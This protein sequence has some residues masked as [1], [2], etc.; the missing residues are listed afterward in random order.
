MSIMDACILNNCIRHGS[1]QQSSALST[2]LLVAMVTDAV[3]TNVS[4]HIQS[5]QLN[6]LRLF[7]TFKAFQ[8]RRKSSRT[9]I[10]IHSSSEILND[11]WQL[12][13]GMS[14]RYISGTAEFNVYVF[15][16]I[17]I[18]EPSR[19]ELSAA[20]QAYSP[21]DKGN[22]FL[23]NVTFHILHNHCRESRIF[24]MGIF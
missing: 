22:R 14:D 6:C 12:Y 7:Q 18:T 2:I 9:G 4:D 13:I 20:P 1:H 19:Y 10:Q 24:R 8:R 15:A 17:I 3:F 16:S 23:R 11:K 21:E 5:K